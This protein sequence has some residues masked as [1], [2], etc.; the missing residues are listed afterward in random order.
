MA[1]DRYIEIR[2]LFH[3]SDQIINIIEGTFFDSRLVGIKQY[4]QGG[5]ALL[6]DFLFYPGL[7]FHQPA[8]DNRLYLP[9]HRQACRAFVQIV[10]NTVIIGIQRATVFIYRNTGRRTG[11]FIQIIGNTVIIGIE[12]D[13]RNRRWS[14]GG[15]ATFFSPPKA[16]VK[17]TVASKLLVIESLSNL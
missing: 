15:A 8:E 3:N 14:G 6:N 4:F 10:W 1:F 9:S 12:D 13:R 16:K 17:P 11:A 5:S 2:I 7:G